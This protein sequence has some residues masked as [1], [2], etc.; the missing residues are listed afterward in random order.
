MDSIGRRQIFRQGDYAGFYSDNLNVNWKITSMCNYKCSYCFGQEPIN[1][2]TFSTWEQL[3]CAADKII[4]LNRSGYR[5]TF[6]GGEPTIHPHLHKLIC[7]L[8]LHLNE[9]IEHFNIITN[10]SRNISY[11]LRLLD[12]IGEFKSTFIVSLH[13]EYISVSTIVQ[14]IKNLSHRASLSFSLMANPEKKEHTQ[15]LFDIL[16]ALRSKYNFRITIKELRQ[17]PHDTIDSRYTAADFQWIDSANAIIKNRDSFFAPPSS[18]SAKNSGHGLFWDMAID[19]E[20]R[21]F[22]GA[23]SSQIRSNLYEFNDMYCIMGSRVLRIGPDGMC[24]G[25]VCSVSRR[26]INLFEQHANLQDTFPFAVVCSY[27]NCGC[28]SN[29][30]IPK[31]KDA[32]EANVFC[33]IFADKVK[34]SL[35]LGTKLFP[36]FSCPGENGLHRASDNIHTTA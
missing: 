12:T 15:E 34:R 14:L 17:P 26:S 32:V 19:G 1:K 33:H 21:I 9:K 4:A 6:T 13:T 22:S 8:S 2:H 30:V 29:H 35:Q 11:Y 27:K 28:V 20:R 5:F 7:Y 16:I 10:G 18:A 36:D 25:A 23:V 3:Q 31:F 24:R